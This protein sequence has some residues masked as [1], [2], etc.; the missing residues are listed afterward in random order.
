[1]KK[2]LLLMTL[3]V[4][5]VTF[6]GAQTTSKTSS[7][8]KPVA[9]VTSS[10]VGKAANKMTVK[11]TQPAKALRTLD[12]QQ[13]DLKILSSKNSSNG[14]AVQIVK[15]T[16]GRI[17]KR[18]VNPNASNKVKLNR[19]AGIAKAE[20]NPAGSLFFESFEGWDG[21]ATNWIPANWTKKSD[22][23]GIPL[24]K[25]WYVSD[26]IEVLGIL[27]VDGKYWAEIH[28][29][30]D[31]ESIPFVFGPSDEWLMSP[32]VT[33][34]QNDKMYFTMFYNPIF[35]YYKGVDENGE[36]IIDRSKAAATMKVMASVDNGNW[37]E[38]WDVANIAVNYTDDELWD[39]TGAAGTGSH[40]A[41]SVDISKYVGKNV[42]FAFRYVGQNGDDM[43]IDAVSIAAPKPVALY[44]RPQGYFTWG[45]TEDFNGISEYY[46]FGPAYE[47]ATWLNRSNADSESFSW[48]FA[49]PTF[50]SKDKVTF[51][52]KNV[53]ITYPYANIKSPVLTASAAGATPATYQWG[54]SVSL[55]GS[56]T[57]TVRVDEAGTEEEWTLGVGNYDLAYK[58]FTLPYFAKGQYCFGTGSNDI[59]EAKID[60]LGNFYEKP[61]HKY[62]ITKFWI[63]LADF[64]A[65]ADAEFNL[66]IH[67]VAGDGSLTDTIATAVCYGAD[68]VTVQTDPSGTKYCTMPFVFTEE[69]ESGREEEVYVEID[70][71][72]LVEMKGFNREGV[73]L[74]A[75]TDGGSAVG[76]SNGYMFAIMGEAGKEERGLLNIGSLLKGMEPSAFLFNMDVTY[77]FLLADDDM[78]TVP[79][80]G[81]NKDFNVTTYF[82][83]QSWEIS[84]PDWV[85]VKDPVD[86]AETGEVT[87]NLEVG[88]MPT[89][90]P[91]RS[92][93]VIVSM[94]GADMKISVVQGT[95]V[96][97]SSTSASK[98]KVISTA[99]AFELS[100]PSDVTSAT[101]FN[102]SGQTV[103]SYQLPESG[104]FT[105]PAS[106]LNKGVYVIKFM[107]NAVSSVKVVR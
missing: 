44:E 70:D 46:L 5:S 34:R 59:W 1:M 55:G 82:V 92:G 14:V 39:Y 66:I 20:G 40:F 42:K 89:G 72:I 41:Y 90:I 32:I 54:N 93:D 95:P 98:V 52:S 99:D 2:N 102:I 37:E 68:V 79:V 15:D 60:G 94:P 30:V 61:L 69:D 3:F 77:P 105:M 4:A 28:C 64:A 50:A 67:R 53:A 87:L 19:N 24:D 25:T 11:Q 73:T 100:Y 23:V 21:V 36:H 96:G 45:F 86:N 106:A 26:G 104:T 27:P 91:G 48:A 12:L 51:T 38:A 35:M 58:G 62:F 43:Y 81:G 16:D 18:I 97:I 88:E 80:A 33:P 83:T 57:M 22:I 8:S 65:P 13:K 49:D 6:A 17:M 107:G 63:H 101:L 84:K 103:A 7:K 75:F 85:T 47:E 71:A 9:N 10:I 78:F 31:Y 29:N 76:G 74:G 56:S